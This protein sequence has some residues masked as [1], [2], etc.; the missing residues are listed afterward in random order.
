MSINWLGK[1]VVAFEGYEGYVEINSLA[2][3]I[4]NSAPLKRDKTDCSLEER[5]NCYEV[6]EGVKQ[7]YKKSHREVNNTC[8]YWVFVAAVEF[9]P[10]CRACAGDPMALIE[11]WEFGST[12]ES[13]FK[14]T[15]EEFKRLWPEINEPTGKSWLV[16]R[17]MLNS[18]TWTASEEMVRDALARQGSDRSGIPRE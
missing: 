3:I 11:E 2:K 9:R 8:L 10:Y 14:F 6:W 4:L 12:R 15:P 17:G 5:L 1:R 13:I 18:E 16:D 7:L